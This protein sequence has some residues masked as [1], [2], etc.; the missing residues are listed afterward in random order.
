MY[1]LILLLPLLHGTTCTV[2][3][4]IP[5]HGYKGNTTCHHCH[6]L[7]HY[8]LNTT[9]Y[10]TS[11]TQL[12][13]LPGLYHP[14]TNIIIKDVYNFSI[15]GFPSTSEQYNNVLIDSN[16]IFILMSNISRLI[17]K[18]IAFSATYP[19]GQHKLSPLLTIKDCF[20][21]TLYNLEIFKYHPQSSISKLNFNLVIINVMGNSSVSNVKNSGLL[22]TLLLY[23]RTQ[24]DKKHHVLTVSNCKI[25]SIKISMLQNSYKMTLMIINM[26]LKYFTNSILI[27]MKF[28]SFIYADEL[29]ANEVIIINCK[30]INY[31]YT[32]YVFFFASSSNGSVKFIDCQ[33][34]NNSNLHS[35]V[36]IA[37]HNL[38]LGPRHYAKPALVKIQLRTNLEFK[39]CYFQSDSEYDGQVFQTDGSSTNPSTIIINN[40]TFSYYISKTINSYKSWYNTDTFDLS[41]I[42]LSNSTL[43]LKNSVAFRKIATL[44]SVISLK[45]NSTIIICGS[46]EFSHNQGDDLINFYDNHK[47]YIIIEENSSLNIAHNNVWSPFAINPVVAR[48]PYPFCIFQYFSNCNKSKVKLEQRFLITFYNNQ[49]RDNLRSDCYNYMI[50][51]HC[52]WLP[53]SLFINSIPLEVNSTYIQ[54]VNNDSTTY[55]LSQKIE[56]D[57]LCVCTS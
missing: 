11:N 1:S 38:Q 32:Q 9:K 56:Q 46:A 53:Q 35:T 14:Y 4:V 43:I 34:V 36:F 6:N 42:A 16:F 17:V 28:D 51:T 2:Y 33:F 50:F 24:T 15:I 44:R 21:I 54:F 19:R 39:N 49:C 45:G 41:F 26:Q 31:M 10:F 27:G 25:I 13:F 48:Y 47:K 29:G 57:S 55:N 20:S 7:Q 18:N 12:L 8:L 5:D 23:N 52:L 30:F 3:T 22:K 37:L 40:S